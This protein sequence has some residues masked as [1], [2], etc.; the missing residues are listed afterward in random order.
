MDL[1]MRFCFLEGDLNL[2]GN[3][4]W[5]II[6]WYDLWPTQMNGDSYLWVKVAR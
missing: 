2:E 1:E 5:P 3:E 4:M 6:W